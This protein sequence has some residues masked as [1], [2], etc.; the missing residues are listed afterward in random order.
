MLQVLETMDVARALLENTTAAHI[1]VDIDP[2]GV[3]VVA[4]VVSHA[5]ST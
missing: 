2:T 5:P 3:G 1:W 4:A